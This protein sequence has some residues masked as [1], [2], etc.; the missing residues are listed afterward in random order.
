M[1]E[2]P[3]TAAG[4]RGVCKF[5]GAALV[6]PQLP[7]ESARLAPPPAA[8]QPSAPPPAAWAPPAAAPMWSP[9]A[10]SPAAPPAWSPPP[11]LAYADFGLRALGYIADVAGQWVIMFVLRP[12][13]NLFNPWPVGNMMSLLETLRSGG[14][15]PQQV[16]GQVD[17]MGIALNALYWVLWGAIL[18]WLY[19]ALFES[20]SL[21]ATPGKLLAGLKVTDMEGRRIGFGRATTRAL[22]K[23]LSALLCYVGYIMAAFTERR[24]ALHDIIAQT[25]VL[26]R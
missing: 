12:V 9:A 10:A 21:Q 26:K 18:Q 13:L 22:A 16:L 24:Q 20:S 19:F 8:P 14:T 3:E 7:G 25:V 23:G 5:C 15:D 2:A 11:T 6:A 1:L 4:Q 17:V